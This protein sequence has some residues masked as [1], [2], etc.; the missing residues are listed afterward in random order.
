MHDGDDETLVRSFRATGDNDSFERLY[1]RH[2]RAIYAC[3]LHFVR[4]PHE[5]EDLCHDVFVTAYERFATLEGESF[6]PWVRRIARNLCLN[7][8]RGERLRGGVEPADEQQPSGDADAARTTIVRQQLERAGAVLETLPPHQR[9]VFLL[10]HAAGLSYVEIAEQTG[11]SREAV[12]SH[13][14]NARRN[15]RLRFERADSREQRGGR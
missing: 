8:L 13:L 14:Q 10:F 6:L 5:A 12:R 1:R 15:F 11:H 2:R 3:C 9:R 4:H 7:R